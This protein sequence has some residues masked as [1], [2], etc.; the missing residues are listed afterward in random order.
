MWSISGYFH[1]LPAFLLFSA[2]IIAPA[3]EEL[4][5]GCGQSTQG[6]LAY[7]LVLPDLR[8]LPPFALRLVYD[9][10]HQRLILRLSNSVWNAGQGSLELRGEVDPTA[11]RLVATQVYHNAWGGE[12]LH[13]V[14]EFVYHPG[15]EHWHLDGFS[16]YEIW[17]LKSDGSL[18]ALQVS[19]GKVSYCLQDTD[20]SPA[21]G[22]GPASSPRQYYACQPQLQGISPGW[23]DTYASDLPGQWLDISNLPDGSYALVSR[24]DPYNL[25]RETNEHNNDAL[26][27]FQ[28]IDRSIRS[29]FHPEEERSAHVHRGKN[30]PL[31]WMRD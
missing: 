14:G 24:T 28:L 16:L 29:D 3:Q 10:D 20:P 1:L 13:R 6:R 17:S 2:Q 5:P 19:S 30:D 18:D 12:E 27:Y 15:H 23:I 4:C 9:E 7:P 26:T 11:G 22:A 25:V 31:R 8:T 21:S